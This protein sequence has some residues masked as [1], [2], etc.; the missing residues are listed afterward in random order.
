LTTEQQEAA[1]EAHSDF[2]TRRGDRVAPCVRD[3]S[4]HIASLQCVGFGFGVEPEWK[5]YIAA[6]DWSYDSLGLD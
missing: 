3:G 1:L 4:F 6:E 5:D 2:Y